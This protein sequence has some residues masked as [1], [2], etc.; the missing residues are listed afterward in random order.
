MFLSMVS[1]PNEKP[2]T[3]LSRDTFAQRFNVAIVVTG[4]D[5]PVVR[6]VAGNAFQRNFSCKYIPAYSQLAQC[7]QQREILGDM[8]PAF[9]V[10]RSIAENANRFELFFLFR[11]TEQP[12]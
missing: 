11:L 4:G 3:P 6:L 7:S 10:G 5:H 2:V 8:L 9:D 12:S 1:A